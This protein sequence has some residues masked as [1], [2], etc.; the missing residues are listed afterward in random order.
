MLAIRLTINESAKAA[1]REKTPATMRTV[2]R[3]IRGSA[4]QVD[5]NGTCLQ[6]VTIVWIELA[7]ATGFNAQFAK[8]VGLASAHNLVF[9]GF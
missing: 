4:R 2:F 5:A 9:E 6:F 1:K 7:I 8:F 3:G